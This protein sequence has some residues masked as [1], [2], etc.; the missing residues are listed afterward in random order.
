[1]KSLV[2]LIVMIFISVSVVAM[3]TKV[4]IVGENITIKEVFEQ[5]ETQS[6][7]TI[8][9]NQTKFNVGQIV[10]RQIKSGTVED[11]LN[12]VLKNSGAIYTVKGSH[13]IIKAKENQKRS[14]AKPTQTIRGVVADEASGQPIPYATV[15]LLNTEP[16]IGVTTDSL[17]RFK[18]ESIPIGRYDIEVSS[19]GY[20]SNI[21]KEVLLI[22]A[23]E[24]FREIRLK[25]QVL[26]L[27]EVVVR[28]SISKEKP[29]N[30]MALAGGRMLS[31]EEANRFA[32]GFDDPARLASSFAGVA[33]NFATNSLSIH[34]NSP[35]FI[36]WKL[37][38][39]EIPFFGT[40]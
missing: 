37:E 22:S 26:Q 33:G 36:Q 31:V 1:M 18:F 3:D 30:N 19:L 38:G 34:G 11:I 12:R 9:Y 27:D 40:E 10:D 4:T 35:Q 2:C 6:K 24:S 7:F 39:V 32:G 28:P 17:G 20:E 13:I 29:L 5:I 8:A 23:K 15:I 16:T 14:S 25:E 21:T